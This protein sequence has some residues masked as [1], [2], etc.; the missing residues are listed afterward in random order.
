MKDYGA[1]VA[2]MLQLYPGVAVGAS[3]GAEGLA[4]PKLYSFDLLMCTLSKVE[5][6]KK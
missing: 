4:Y 1:Q 5:N 6:E 2:F 3:V